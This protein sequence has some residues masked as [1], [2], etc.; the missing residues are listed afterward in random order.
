MSHLSYLV[1]NTIS[2]I[3]QELTEEL[4]LINL[5]DVL[6]SIKFIDFNRSWKNKI[7][8]GRAHV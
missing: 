6:K 7:Q 4:D 5:Y 2:L 1:E 8:I 3:L